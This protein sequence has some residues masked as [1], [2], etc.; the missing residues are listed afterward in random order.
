MTPHWKPGEIVNS[1]N[2]ESER[3]NFD[4]GVHPAPH[5]QNEVGLR[6]VSNPVV[7][8]PYGLMGDQS[9]RRLWAADF[10][11][12]LSAIVSMVTVIFLPDY[13]PM[14]KGL[15]FY[16]IYLIYFQLTEFY[17]GTTPAKWWF[18]LCVRDYRG[19]RPTA[20]QIGIRT[21]F[22]LLEVNPLFVGAFP[23]VLFVA[24]TERHVRLG[25]LVAGTVVTRV[26]NVPRNPAKR[27]N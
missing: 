15:T 13:D 6:T 11:F 23:A 2:D 22:R 17:W 4:L 12:L 27:R 14:L 26:E 5:D 21:L 16:V 1:E 18:S 10:D 25:D 9:I 8:G 19:K 20:A 3:S 7:I 24:M